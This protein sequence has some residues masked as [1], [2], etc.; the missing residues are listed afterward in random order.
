MVKSYVLSVEECGREWIGFR[1]VQLHRKI[2]RNEQSM[3][4]AHKSH[5]RKGIVR[6]HF[7]HVKAS[8]STFDTVLHGNSTLLVAELAIGR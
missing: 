5:C 2:I 3:S 1:L 7:L 4:V 8:P 6:S